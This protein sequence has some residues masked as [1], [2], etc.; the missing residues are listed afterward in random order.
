M[1]VTLTRRTGNTSSL[2]WTSSSA[3][4]LRPAKRSILQQRNAIGRL[5]RREGLDVGE[6]VRDFLVGQHRRAI[7]RHVAWWRIAKNVAKSR[8]AQLGL[9]E[10]G[11]S[12]AALPAGSMAF[13]ARFHFEQA[14]AVSDTR[15][16][17][18]GHAGSEQREE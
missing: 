1:A 3:T 9:R 5:R 16:L 17:R 6:Q 8:Q 7:R 18:P 12:Q 4:S 2:G 14:L 11:S 13:V 10:A 15:I